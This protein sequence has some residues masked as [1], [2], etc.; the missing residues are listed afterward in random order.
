MTKGSKCTAYVT[1]ITLDGMQGGNL[2]CLMSACI[3][4]DS[5]TVA[6]IRSYSA[7]TWQTHVTQ[8]PRHLLYGY[9][10]GGETLAPQSTG[11]KVR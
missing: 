10:D 6:I 3:S 4:V 11:I 7:G 2:L 9:P 5:P 1:G 8:V